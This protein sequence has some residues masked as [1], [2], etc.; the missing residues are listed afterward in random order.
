MRSDAGLSV[1]ELVVG[2]GIVAGLLVV[3]GASLP[4]SPAHTQTDATAILAFV[5]DARTEVILTGRAGVVNIGRQEMS[6]GDQR[7]QWDAELAVT[8]GAAAPVTGYRLLLEPDGSYSGV[9]LYVRSPTA[10]RAVPGVYSHSL[11]D[12]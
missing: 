11:L 5:A 8:A 1:L 2:L 3:V 7:I 10:T 4:R 12:G 6:F 9:P